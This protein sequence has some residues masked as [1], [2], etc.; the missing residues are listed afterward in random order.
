M[1][2]KVV[3]LLIAMALTFSGCDKNTNDAQD[4]SMIERLEKTAAYTI[5][6]DIETGVI[7]IRWYE[8]GITPMFNADGSL[9]IWKE[10]E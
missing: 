4:V 8:G 6:R 3:M 9:K 10:G 5:F 7:Y 1:K 2:K